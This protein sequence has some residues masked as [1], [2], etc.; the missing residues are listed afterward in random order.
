MV[1]YD[2]LYDHMKPDFTFLESI[3]ISIGGTCTV[4]TNNGETYDFIDAGI[5]YNTKTLS[6][7]DTQELE[8]MRPWDVEYKVIKLEDI[9]ELIIEGFYINNK[10]RKNVVKVIKEVNITKIPRRD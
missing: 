1:Q 2:S 3:S 5:N 4:K 9:T 7:K 6:G 8:T 10:N